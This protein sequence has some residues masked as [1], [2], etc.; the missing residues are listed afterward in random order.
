MKIVLLILKILLGLALLIGLILGGIILYAMLTDFKPEEKMTVEHLG[1]SNKTLD[2]NEVSLLVWNIGYCGLGA[3]MDFFYDGGKMVRPSK[4]LVSKYYAGVEKTLS[5]YKNTDFILLQEVD[6]GSKRSHY[7]NEAEGIAKSLPQMNHAFGVNYDVKFVPLPFTDPMGRVKSGLQ[8]LS[9]YKSTENTR[10][11]FPGNFSF[12]KGL[13]FLDRCFL[14]QRFPLNNGKEL[15]V[16]N[17]HNS[18][19]DDGS[20]KAKQMEYLKKVLMDEY[21]KGNYVIVGGD[22]NQTPPGFDNNTFK[23]PGDK[24]T[25]DQ[26]A[27]DFDY[28]P[29]DWLW[30]YD[31]QVPTNRKNSTPYEKM[32]TFTT[33]IDFCLLSPNIQL[34]T[35]KGVDIDFEYSD[36][37]PIYF[38]VILKD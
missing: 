6:M 8:S 20:L 21:E 13:F 15:I 14:L 32:R 5:K 30:A 31:P 33:V 9:P 36:H 35:V 25:Y 19:Y 22:W 16:I 38:E 37:Q 2:K 1:T 12:P 4:D 7:L 10:Y 23:K 27:V 24:E 34:K 26:I 11:Q 17:T 29:Q 28:M 18:A 3:E